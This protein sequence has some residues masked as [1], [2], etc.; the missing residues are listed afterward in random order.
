MHIPIVVSLLVT[1]VAM[2]PSVGV[3]LIATRG[4]KS[5]GGNE[6]SPTKPMSPPAGNLKLASRPVRQTR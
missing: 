5:S 4:R 1:L 2:V 3:S 6:M